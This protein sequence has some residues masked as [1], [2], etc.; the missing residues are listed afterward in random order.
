MTPKVILLI[1]LLQLALVL[2]SIPLWSRHKGWI[3]FPVTLL[4]IYFIFD[5]AIV[6]YTGVK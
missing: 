2:L 6:A 4:F 3:L 1:V 5:A